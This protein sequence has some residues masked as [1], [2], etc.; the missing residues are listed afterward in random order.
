MS[1]NKNG[2]ILY[3][4]W[5]GY[6]DN[7]R[8]HHTSSVTHDIWSYRPEAGETAFKIEAAGSFEKLSK[9]NGEDRNPVFAADGDT[10][11]YLSEQDGSFNI[12]KSSLSSPSETTQI[13]RLKTHPVRYLSLSE[14]GLMSFSYNGELYTV[15]DGEEPVKVD[16]TIISDS[17][18]RENIVRYMSGYSRDFAISPNGKEV[19]VIMRGDVFV[20]SIDHST[21]KRITDTPQ[22]ERDLCFSE[23]GKTIYY[24]AE[25]DGSWGIFATSLTEKGDKYFTYAVKMEE[26]RITDPGQT[27]FQP[28]IS[29]DGK[30]L[31][32]LRDRTELVIKDIKSGKEKSLHKMINYSYQDGD[33]SFQWSPD[34]KYILCNWQANGGWNNE[35]LQM[36]DER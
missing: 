23:D 31:G 4:D 18:E 6:E 2:T 19:A 14:N 3:E 36:G 9:F 5:K 12:Y 8:K 35:E 15:K 11:F 30:W 21:T 34:S 16:I 28:A 17:N 27:C 10:Y 22:Q 1:V 32:F 7:F 20:T 13:T 26:K 29:P 25:R 24:S 33:Q